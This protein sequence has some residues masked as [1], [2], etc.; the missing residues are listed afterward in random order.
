VRD[1]GIDYM[2]QPEF[3][4]KYKDKLIKSAS[5]TKNKKNG[6]E[7]TSVDNNL[8][9]K[10]ARE[11]YLSFIKD[12]RDVYNR[13]K[14][15]VITSGANKKA[16]IDLFI[17]TR[18][19]Y[20]LHMADL[21]GRNVSADTKRVNVALLDRVP[22]K[23]CQ[24]TAALSLLKNLD[25][26]IAPEFDYETY[27]CCDMGIAQWLSEF[28]LAHNK[29]S[30]EYLMQKIEPLSQTLVE[31]SEM[32]K[33]SKVFDYFSKPKNIN[34]PLALKK[35]V[36]CGKLRTSSDAYFRTLYNNC[37]KAMKQGTEREKIIYTLMVSGI[38][39]AD[40]LVWLDSNKEK[41]DNH[42]AAYYIMSI[43]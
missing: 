12:Q 7:E 23:L 20:S 25:N 8:Y 6:E 14:P 17:D 29:N 41:T 13:R 26:G 4:E 35:S 36:L 9:K 43:K 40:K 28:M 19:Q 27:E 1:V 42:I 32:T 18:N 39:P 15:L 38:M 22:Q 2:S 24:F 3:E 30:V 11:S 31:K 10:I 5:I 33:V 34:V 16:I 21:E 37:T